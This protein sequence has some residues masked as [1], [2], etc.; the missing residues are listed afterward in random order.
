M[1]VVIPLEVKVR[2]LI[3]K[4]FLAYKILKEKKI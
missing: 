4:I 2:E 1:L 3:S